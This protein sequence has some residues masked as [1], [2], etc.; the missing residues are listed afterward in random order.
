MAADIALY[1]RF[2]G[3]AA[4]AAFTQKPR[5]FLGNKNVRKHSTAR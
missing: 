2:R 1:V 4:D 5:K 3:L